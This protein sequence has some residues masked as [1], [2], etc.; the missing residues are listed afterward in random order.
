MTCI[1]FDTLNKDNVS[2]STGN[3]KK[4]KVNHCKTSDI[5]FKSNNDKSRRSFKANKQ[6]QAKAS[7]K[8]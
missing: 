7:R 4:P 3:V 5:M 2:P 1:L 8:Q 6:T